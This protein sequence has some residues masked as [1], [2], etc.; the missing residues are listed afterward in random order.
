MSMR[1]PSKTEDLFLRDLAAKVLQTRIFGAFIS[2]VQ[3]RKNEDGLTRKDLSERSARWDETGVSKLLS[4]PANWTISKI[5]DLAHSLDLQFHF[6]LVDQKKP[7]RIFTDKGIKEHASAVV[8]NSAVITVNMTVR[9][10]FMDRITPMMPRYI[11]P[12]NAIESKNKIAPFKND[13]VNIETKT[14]HGG[15]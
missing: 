11:N 5:S 2:A 3:I 1:R 10:T 9:S 7:G 8:T 14:Q 13:V 15:M 4:S 12:V 6:I